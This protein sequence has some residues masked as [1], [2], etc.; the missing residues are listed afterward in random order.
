MAGA[1]KEIK[2]RERGFKGVGK[3]WVERIQDT[4]LF[5]LVVFFVN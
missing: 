3:D 5:C 1:K 4:C 2:R